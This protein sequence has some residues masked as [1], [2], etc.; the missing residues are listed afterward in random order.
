MNDDARGLTPWPCP[1]D[2]PVALP[3]SDSRSGFSQKTVRKSD[4]RFRTQDGLTGG[5]GRMSGK[6]F[7]MMPSK[8]K[9]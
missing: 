7:G 4:R 9:S 1:R 3:V 8:S 6:T 5:N 2:I